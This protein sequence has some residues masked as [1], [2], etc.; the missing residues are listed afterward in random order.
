MGCEP[1]G[2]R[3]LRDRASKAL[4]YHLVHIHGRSDRVSSPHPGRYRVPPPSEGWW[5]LLQPRGCHAACWQQRPTGALVV[6]GRTAAGRSTAGAGQGGE[7]MEG[8]RRGG[9]GRRRG[10]RGPSVELENVRLRGGPG[11]PRDPPQEVRTPSDRFRDPEV[12]GSSGG[13]RV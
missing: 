7:G 4:T 13:R 2:G 5:R 9:E 12:P 11:K 1:G 8:E 6:A 3:E 10:R